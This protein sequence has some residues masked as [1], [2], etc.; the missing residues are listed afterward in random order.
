MDGGL[1]LERRVVKVRAQRARLGF[2][3]QVRVLLLIGDV[4][5]AVSRVVVDAIDRVAGEAGETGL[6]LDGG[7]VDRRVHGAGEHKRRVVAP[8]AP[9]ALDPPRRVRLQPELP[10]VRDH[11]RPRLQR[12]LPHVLDRRRIEGVVEGGEAVRRGRPLGRHIRVA[13]HALC[14][15]DEFIRRESPPL[16]LGADARRA[17]PGRLRR[18]FSRFRS[19]DDAGGQIGPGACRGR[20]REERAPG[21]DEARRDEVILHEA[22]H[23]AVA[24]P[25]AFVEPLGERGFGLRRELQPAVREAVPRDEQDEHAPRGE[26]EAAGPHPRWPRVAHEPVSRVGGDDEHGTPHVRPPRPAVLPARRRGEDEESGEDEDAAHESHPDAG[27]DR[28]AVLPLPHRREV[29]GQEP[30]HDR[31]Q[32]QPD[33]GVREHHRLE[34]LGQRVL[35]DREEVESQ[36]VREPV[37]QQVERVRQHED[38]DAEPEPEPALEPRAEDGAQH[39]PSARRRGPGAARSPRVGAV[40]SVVPLFPPSSAHASTKPRGAGGRNR[41]S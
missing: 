14:G 22:R 18:E 25:G 16:H 33:P 35:P 28:S 41:D 6:R 40:S 19:G 21:R 27:Q 2:G 23:V 37:R 12:P 11:L 36:S 34:Q 39:R 32:Q 1:G 13:A 31:G 29:R 30:E 15:A 7:G 17:L 9:L 26:R 4:V 24:A 5:V 8:A 3:E 38:G 20:R 10:Q